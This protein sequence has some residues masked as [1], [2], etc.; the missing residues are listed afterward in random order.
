MGKMIFLVP[1]L[2]ALIKTMFLLT[3][4]IIIFL[5]IS[6]TITAIQTILHQNIRGITNKID[7]FL[8]SLPVNAPQVICVTE[9]HLKIEEI[10]NVNFGQYT[11]GSAY[12]RHT[13]KQGGCV[14]LYF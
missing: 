2:N 7:E 13:F 10:C 14:Y 4:T 6:Y 9:H 1:L 8:I 3:R 11:L 12:C 5:I